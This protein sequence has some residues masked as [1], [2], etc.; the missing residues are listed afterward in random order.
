MKTTCASC[1][2]IIPY[3]SICPCRVE[4]KKEHDKR[5]DRCGRNKEDAVIY[6]NRQWQVV[7][8]IAMARDN[9]LC[10]VCL[11]EKRIHPADMVHHIVEV[12]EDKRTAYDVDNLIS[13]CNACHANVHA[14]YREDSGRERVRL[15][16]LL[17]ER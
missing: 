4:A 16:S 15:R 3:R 14:A 8:E 13:L 5:Y 12:S 9:G 17:P 11:S 6:K 2:K 7:R 10:L 1:G